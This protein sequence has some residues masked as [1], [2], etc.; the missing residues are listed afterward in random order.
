ML[1]LQQMDFAR[2]FEL[3]EWRW[4]TDQSLG[5]Q[6]ISGKPTW[7]GEAGKS[8][9]IWSE[10]GVGDTLMFSTILSE[11]QDICSSIIMRCDK[12]LIPLFERSFSGDISFVPNKSIVSED[13]YDYQIAI[14]SLP[15]LFR[16]DLESFKKGAKGF[17]RADPD[18]IQHLKN[19]LQADTQQPLCGISWRGGKQGAVRSRSIDLALLAQS[20]SDK[21]YRLVNLQYDATA[22]ELEE[23]K[24][25]HGIEVINVAEVDN[26]H[27]LDGLAALLSACDKVVSV[28]NT[29]VH[30]AGT[31]G[32]QTDVLLPFA[33]SWRWGGDSSA[34]YW[35]D[36]LTLYRQEYINNWQQ[37]LEQVRL[38]SEPSS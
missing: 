14:G 22:E 37:P 36:A 18:R 2:G 32:V 20:L 4:Q 1:Y 16:N 28:A 29:T 19:I 26:F 35:Y 9:F 8:V 21:N 27:D 5:E 10:Q 34:S 13:D 31:L 25:N 17:L 30:L 12:R 38:Q 6:L 24:T 15:K 33:P 7:S 23:L 3:C 11:L